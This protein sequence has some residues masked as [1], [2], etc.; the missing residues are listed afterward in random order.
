MYWCFNCGQNLSNYLQIE[1]NNR[2]SEIKYSM[3]HARLGF[4]TL[5]KQL[6]IDK[7]GLFLPQHA[8]Y[9]YH[10][11]IMTSSQRQV[12]NIVGE[13]VPLQNTLEFPTLNY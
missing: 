7:D 1:T 8:I 13:L 2:D 3:Y 5:H 11:Y 6:H 9:E 10:K 12:G 4:T